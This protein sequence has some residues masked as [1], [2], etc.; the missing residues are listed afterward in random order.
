MDASDRAPKD[1][2][3]GAV[4]QT[5][6]TKQKQ[7]QEKQKKQKKK[8]Q[9]KH[10]DDEETSSAESDSSDAD[11]SASEAS[12]VE[13]AAPKKAPKA[14]PKKKAA[15]P[16]QSPAAKKVVT[17]PRETRKRTRGEPEVAAEPA[18]AEVKVTPPTVPGAKLLEVPPLVDAPTTAPAVPS[19]SL[20]PAS[21]AP[22]AADERPIFAL[23]EERMQR[24]MDELTTLVRG[25][26]E[27]LT[28]L[29]T[30]FA[31]ATRGMT[32]GHPQAM[33]EG[34]EALVPV[35]QF[36]PQPSYYGQFGPAYY[37]PPM[38]GGWR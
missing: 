24:Q 20:P 2:Q 23:F 4:K 27:R 21:P 28:K 1:G 37:G 19:V 35:A 26:S 33:G 12:E 16:V 17:P 11:S 9:K 31:L 6:Q 22:R 15:P 38:R 5:K 13:V 36:G 14:A 7:K 8:K 10:E 18:R 34:T 29:Q 32:M 30:D 25:I 3:P